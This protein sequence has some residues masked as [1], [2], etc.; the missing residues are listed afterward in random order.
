MSGKALEA[1]ILVV[2][3]SVALS[4]RN[5]Y[6][7]EITDEVLSSTFF[8]FV[9]FASSVMI[10]LISLQELFYHCFIYENNCFFA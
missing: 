3:D 7:V 9:C 10:V 1:N 6:F 5:R 4:Y 8:D 2:L